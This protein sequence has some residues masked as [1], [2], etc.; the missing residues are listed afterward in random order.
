[1][2]I[3]DR[4][5]SILDA[6]VPLLL[7]HGADITTKDIA[8]AAGIAEG[9]IFRAFSDKDELIQQAVARFMDPEPTF[10]LLEAIDPTLELEDKV[11]Q[12]VGIFR[13]RFVGV[14]GVVSALGHKKPMH[15]HDRDP[16][17]DERARDIFR[18]L[19]ASDADRFRIDPGLAVYFM[20]LLSFGA[21]MPMF[22]A[23]RDVDSEQLVD[24][25]MQGIAKEGR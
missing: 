21:A 5:A 1:M 16:R 12:V 3:E 24:F 23:E 6:V 11:R 20:R 2:S 14:V 22:T 7:S 8:D 9:T 13:E 18:A 19:F 15:S 17:V 25:I 4:R 10:V